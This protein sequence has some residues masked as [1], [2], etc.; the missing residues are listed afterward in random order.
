MLKLNPVTLLI[1]SLISIKFGIFLG[2]FLGS[3]SMYTIT[4]MNKVLLCLLYNL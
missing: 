3:F 1:N 4:S 2:G